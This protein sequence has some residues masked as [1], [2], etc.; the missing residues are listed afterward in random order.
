MK[1]LSFLLLLFLAFSCKKAEAKSTNKLTVKIPDVN[2]EKALIALG[3]DDKQDGELLR[4]SAVKVINLDIWDQS[5]NSI[6]GIEAFIN[7]KSLNCGRN[8]LE[9]IDVSKNIALTKLHIYSNKLTSIDVSKNI[10]LVEL[11][12]SN[13]QLTSIDVSKNTIL[14]NLT[15]IAG[16]SL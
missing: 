14:E 4:S 12:C 10:G 6:K 15:H 2:F 1:K 9:S 7:L 16:I 13:N 3:I 8:Q 5:I 11:H